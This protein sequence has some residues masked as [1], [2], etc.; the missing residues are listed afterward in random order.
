MIEDSRSGESKEITFDSPGNQR[1][2]AIELAQVRSMRAMVKQ[3]VLARDCRQ[4]G[5][6]SG[7]SDR[8][9]R[10]SEIVDEIKREVDRLF[11][12]YHAE[13]LSDN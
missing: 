7:Y 9:T 8:C 5:D 10:A 11:L 1:L 13:L 2:T 4:R 12:V 3:L 6:F